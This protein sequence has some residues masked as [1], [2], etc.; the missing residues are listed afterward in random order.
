MKKLADV[1]VIGIVLLG[2]MLTPS[3]FAEKSWYVRTPRGAR[4]Q[5]LVT[6]S[7]LKNVRIYDLAFSE[8]GDMFSITAA[9]RGPSDSSISAT[10]SFYDGEY[11]VQDDYVDV[12]PGKTTQEINCP[13]TFDRMVLDYSGY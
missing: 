12:G 1:S 6:D 2:L 5:L 4:I 13:E 3:A 7:A 9:P 11:S 8:S 10:I